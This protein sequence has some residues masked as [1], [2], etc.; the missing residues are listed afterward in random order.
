VRIS[1]NL[2]RW[3]L[4]AVWIAAAAAN[5]A[6]IRGGFLTNYAADLAVP[7][8]LYVVLREQA[9]EG[10]KHRL[11]PWAGRSAEATGAMIFTGAALTEFAQHFWPRG[12]LP[13][14]FDPLDIV[15]YAAGIAACYLSERKW[16][17]S[18]VSSK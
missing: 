17:L 10:R 16:P 3:A 4:F 11:L 15:A 14:T 5:M 13:G 9:A 1:W 7:A 18:G 2:A 12:V 8:W 6:R